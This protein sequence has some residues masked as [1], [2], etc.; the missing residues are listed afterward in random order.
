MDVVTDEQ[1]DLAEAEVVLKRL[2]E[3]RRELNERRTALQREIE[4]FSRGLDQADQDARICAVMRGDYGSGERRSLNKA[5][6]E[7]SENEEELR[8]L[9]VAIGRAKAEL[10]AAR[11]REARRIAAELQPEHD[12]IAARIV[13]ALEEL[14][15]A[16]ADERA[17]HVRIGGD[18]AP[19]LPVLGRPLLGADHLLAQ[20]REILA[21]RRAAA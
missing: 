1:V 21:T 19:I 14:L 17:L 16:Q 10:G 2:G 5:L 8:L 11:R 3:R 20:A 4:G 13:A 15:A 6:D 7:A 9:Q 12:A 18:Q